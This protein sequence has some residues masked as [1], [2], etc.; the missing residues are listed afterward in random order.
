MTSCSNRP[1]WRKFIFSTA[2]FIGLLSIFVQS[3]AE[4]PRI[5]LVIGNNSYQYVKP[6]YNAVADAHLFRQELEARGFSVV[7]LE[8]ATRHEMN[9]GIEEFLGKLST[10]AISVVFYSGHGVQINNTNYLLPTD[11][12]ADK[13]SDVIN[14]GIELGRLMERTS[15]M[16]TKFTLAVIDACRNN[17]FREDG[18]AIGTNKGLAPPLGEASGIMIVYAAGANQQALDK[19]GPNDHDPNGLFTR[20]FIKAMRQPGLTVQEVVGRVKLAV[21][22][23][24]KSAGKIQTPAIYDQSLGTFYF[25]AQADAPSQL[26]LTSP[27]P[28]PSPSPKPAVAELSPQIT[29]PAS[30]VMSAPSSATPI[31]SVAPTMARLL[32]G[33]FQMGSPTSE[34]DREGDE[35]QHQACV[36]AFAIGRYEVTNAEFRR[37]RSEH[38]SGDTNGNSMN[39]DQQPVVNVSWNEAVAYAQWLSQ[40]TGKHYRLPTEAEWEYACRSGVVGQRY[41]GGDDVDSVAW[42]DGNSDNKTHAVGQKRANAWDLYDMSGN[43]W[44]WTCSEYKDSYDG[45][46]KTC[47][48]HTD[49]AQRVVRGGSWLNVPAGVRSAAR[50]W[51]TPDDRNSDLGFRL[52]QD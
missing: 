38:N 26:T 6:L 46:E 24:A 16:Q 48:N 52:V 43:V 45:S 29:T 41:C 39:G 28:S 40:Q 27:S 10:D 21:I 14:D 18:R 47:N 34:A 20:E 35:Q 22:A 2:L 1:L 49:S 12:Q 11:L 4:E 5:A 44:E 51:N 19:L 42:Y 31:N 37:F 33:C 25:T 15:Q 17:P 50:T 13:P 36:N 23:Q 7:Y 8:N 3:N 30:K 9:N 32:G